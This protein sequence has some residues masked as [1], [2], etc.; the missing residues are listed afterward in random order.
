TAKVRNLHDYESRIIHGTIP[1][2]SGIDT[3]NNVR[4]FSQIL[5]TLLKDVP[6]SPYEMLPFPEKDSARMAMYA[7]LDFKGL[8]TAL[9]QLLDIAPIIQFG[10]R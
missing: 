10:H 8:Y 4:Y 9:V 6:K 1:V 2:P 5:L 3:A 7:S